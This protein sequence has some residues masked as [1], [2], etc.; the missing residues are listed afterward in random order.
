MQV[1]APAAPKRVLAPMLALREGWQYVSRYGPIRTILLHMAT[2]SLL[3][4]PYTVLMP[5]VAT[6]ILHGD[7]HTQGYLMAGSGVGALCGAL[8]LATRKSVLGLGR[9]IS[10][11]TALLGVGLIA[12]SFSHVL[13]LSLL[14]L[15]LLGFGFMVQMAS[16]NT[17]LQTIV[18]EDKRGRVM[19]F[20][21]MSFMGTA[22]FGSLLAGA[23]SH[24]YGVPYTILACGVCSLGSAAWFA[25]R[26]PALRPLVHPIYRGL[27][28]LPPEVAE[29]ISEATELVGQP[30]R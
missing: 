15:P 4:T 7:A 25:S 9:V 19:S 28:I 29:G 26:L 5:A 6:K 22:P 14:L 2:V 11:A 23:M 10:L 27:G 1:L 13:W 8:F 18:E 12:F 21:T 16:C 17:L 20:F 30:C 24:R 3:G